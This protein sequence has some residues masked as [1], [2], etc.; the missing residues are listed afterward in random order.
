MSEFRHRSPVTPDSVRT[1][2]DT[3]A[4]PT[5]GR[6]TPVWRRI[7]RGALIVAAGTAA[8]ALAG[9]MALR[10]I[11]DVAGAAGAV[12]VAFVLDFGGGPGNQVVGCVNVDPTHSRYAALSE[13][14][15]QKNLVLPAYADS[16]LLCSINGVPSAGCGQTVSGGYIYWSYFTGG[17]S[18]WTYS[19]TGAFGPVTQGDV[20][21]WRF[22]N[23]GSGRPN[24]PAPRTAPEFSSLCSAVAT[25]T[26]TRP[27]S[28]AGGPTA[29][30]SGAAVANGS[31]GGSPAV[32]RSHAH[33]AAKP[34]TIQS[35]G[36]TGTSVVASAPVP[37]TTSTIPPDPSASRTDVIVPSDPVVPA[38]AI[39]TDAGVG[40]GPDSMIV[41]GLLVAG[42][43]GAAYARWRR[44]SRTP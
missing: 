12:T 31:A 32:Y 17:A 20:E 21:G 22:Q 3:V 19:S 2:P 38:A 36:S 33:P 24:D 16:G 37:T 35:T 15:A 42:L 39:N 1:G 13:F 18:G 34:G 30:G 26:T 40:G 28:H 11:S 6:L 8:L 5:H 9:P 23:P 25:T 4:S 29:G 41:G 27:A 7:G 10:P 44:R 14:A 43:A